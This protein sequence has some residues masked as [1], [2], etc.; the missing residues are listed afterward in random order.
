VCTHGRPEMA[1][2]A[3]CS[4]LDQGVQDV[5]VV[6]NA[7]PDDSTRRIL[8]ARAP[9]ARYVVEPVQGLDFARNR[10]LREAR[11]D[12]VA[13]LDDDAVAAPGW[14]EVLE[15]VFDSG[16]TV[17]A[18]T[19]RVE[20]LRLDS[21]GPLLF[22]ANGGYAR[23]LERIR[24]P[25]DAKLRLHGRRAPLIAWAVSVGS[26][27]SFA[28]RR[29]VALDAGGFDVALDLGEELPGG[30]DHD[31]LWRILEAGYEIVYAPEA[32]AYHEH[33][34]DVEAVFRQ[35]AGHQLGLT[36][37]L[38]KTTMTVHGRARLSALAFLLW[39][40]VKPGVR[41]VR[42]TVGRDPLPKRA[43]WRMWGSALAGGP[44]YFAARR[45]ARRR[46]AAV[47]EERD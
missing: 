24:L 2:R 28:L 18:C 19:V 27:C 3:V 17:G 8:E 16:P 20:A 32:L 13:F 39:R 45:I 30:G 6:D 33:R 23:G 1:A 41:L 5:L 10:A 14:V 42:A 15:R 26:G 35:M 47:R 4:L 7:P 38:T 9:S 40:L 12:V 44:A 29:R 43:L 37:F 36:A 22:E 34:E 11:G 25:A 31:M 21:P 46:A